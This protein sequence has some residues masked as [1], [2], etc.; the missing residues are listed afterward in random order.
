MAGEVTQLLNDVRRGD[1][2]AFDRLLPLVYDELRKTASSYLHHEY[3]QRTMQTTDLV[4]E[5]YLRLVGSDV[6]WESRSYF[7]GVA[8]RVMRQILVDMARR[9]RADK[10][11]GE[12]TRVTLGEN[13]LIEEADFERL[14]VLDDALRQLQ[15]VDE[16]L[17]KVVELRYFAGLTVEETAA[18]LD[19]SEK[20]VRNDW[21]LARAWLLKTLR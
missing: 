15:H 18:A 17:C 21:S 13:V 4:H 1:R 10:R 11:G 3:K 20:T 6:S 8:A 12:F 9:R 5:A 14:L 2:S 7:F 16:R 19:V